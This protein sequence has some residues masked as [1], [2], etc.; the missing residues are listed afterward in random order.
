M[1]C[2]RVAYGALALNSADPLNDAIKGSPG[3]TGSCGTGTLPAGAYND[4]CGFGGFPLVEA[5]YIGNRGASLYILLFNGTLNLSKVN[6][7]H[8]IHHIPHRDIALEV[9]PH[10]RSA[11]IVMSLFVA[12]LDDVSNFD[13]G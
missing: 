10:V 8:M 13:I 4:R 9:Q 2:A 11:L 5:V 7:L 3:T 1:K 6:R 12:I